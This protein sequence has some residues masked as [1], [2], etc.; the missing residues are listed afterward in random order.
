MIKVKET[1]EIWIWP[2]MSIEEATLVDINHRQGKEERRGDYYAPLGKRVVSSS[3]TFNVYIV[4]A[5]LGC[6]ALDL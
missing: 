2:Y 5:T 3:T 6:E 4:I 1:H